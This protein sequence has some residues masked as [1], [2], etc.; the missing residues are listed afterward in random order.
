MNLVIDNTLTKVTLDDPRRLP[1]LD[2]IYQCLSYLDTSKVFAARLIAKRQ[3]RCSSFTGERKSFYS[4]DSRVFLTGFLSRVIDCLALNG[5]PFTLTD[6]RLKPAGS[7]KSGSFAVDGVTLRAYQTNALSAFMGHDIGGLAFP[8]GVIHAATGSGKTEI[9]ASAI[10]GLGV[11]ALFLTHRVHLLHQTA[12]RFQ[13]RMPEL[14]QRIGAIGDGIYE[15][16]FVTVATVQTLY[17]MLKSHS[18]HTR[19][20]LSK[21]RLLIIDEAHR[22]GASQFY[23][24][25]SFCQN[26]Y[27]RMALTATPFMKGNAH[28]DMMLM[29]ISGGTVARVTNF[30]LIEAGVLARPFFSFLAVNSPDISHLSEW[31]DIYKA[32]IIY[33]EYRNQLIA[34]QAFKLAKAKKKILVIVSE[35]KHGKILEDKIRAAGVR[36]EYVDG[37]NTNS[38]RE[39]ALTLLSK[40]ELDAIVVTNIFDEG[41][42]VED[43]SAVI[44]AAGNKSAPA[45]FQRTGRAIRKKAEDNYA[46]IIDF[47]DNTHHVL[48]RHS[49]NRYEIVR[50]EAGFTIL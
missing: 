4:P 22:S 48:K 41:I 37:K 50:N 32:G 8:R 45:L 19:E 29:G 35:T 23:T 40:D 26:A 46:I 42:D 44:L 1:A 30:E 24:T 39:R 31:R 6:R 17:S 33:N 34:G 49:R 47:I 13:K 28:D 18:Q 15:P 3:E 14:A 25:A 21:Y 36:V 9:A 38:E 27:Y 16:N 2:M 43:I 20:L 12:R 7:H 5:I 10:R 11:P